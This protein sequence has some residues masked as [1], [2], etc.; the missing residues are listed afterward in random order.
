V[1]RALDRHGELREVERLHHEVE[2][3]LGDRVQR[4]LDAGVRR[5]EEDRHLRV[6]PLDALDELDAVDARHAQVGQHDIDRAVGTQALELLDERSLRIGIIDDVVTARLE[7]RDEDFAQVG[8]VFENQ[9]TGFAI[10]S[11]FR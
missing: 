9:K 5:H 7:I 10:G 4:D 11:G 1:E 3:A 2:G 6:H 8:V